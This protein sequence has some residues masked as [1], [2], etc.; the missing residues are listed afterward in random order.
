M[1]SIM[2]NSIYFKSRSEVLVCRT[3]AEKIHE[4]GS[5]LVRNE[6][7]IFR[8]YVWKTQ[9]FESPPLII[10]NFQVKIQ[11]SKGVTSDGP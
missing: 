2:Q 4:T 5:M 6:F 3:N 9:M 11:K 7:N 8:L 10:L 1:V